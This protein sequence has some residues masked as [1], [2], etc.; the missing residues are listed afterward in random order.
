MGVIG[1]MGLIVKGWRLSFGVRLLTM[2]ATGSGLGVLR[3]SGGRPT[4]EV[5][6]FEVGGLN[7]EGVAGAVGRSGD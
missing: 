7:D 2:A 5:G 3:V 1:R 4:Y 6:A